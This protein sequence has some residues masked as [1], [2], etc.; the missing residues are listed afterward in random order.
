[1]KL[2]SE[3]YIQLNRDLYGV[4]GHVVRVSNAYGATQ[5]RGRGQG[6]VAAFID[7]ARRGDVVRAYGDG[8]I[9]LD[10]TG[11]ASVVG[12]RPRHLRDG[13]SDTWVTCSDVAVARVVGRTPTRS[14]RGSMTRG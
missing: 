8:S 12:W 2:V 11:L 13:I 4:D 7:A 5:V 6:V 10:V 3:H 14:S 1:M 9:V